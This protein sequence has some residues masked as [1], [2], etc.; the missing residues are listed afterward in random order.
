MFGFDL[1]PGRESDHSKRF[2]DR[3][4]YRGQHQCILRS[5]EKAE[6]S[7]QLAAGLPAAADD[8]EW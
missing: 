2:W 3:D 1:S 5:G 8:Y 4:R 6:P 7:L